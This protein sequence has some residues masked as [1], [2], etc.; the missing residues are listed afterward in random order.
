MKNR[1]VPKKKTGAER[2]YYLQRS[3]SRVN[4][5]N[6]LGGDKHEKIL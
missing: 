4:I 6:N 2:K 5:T 1:P 3:E